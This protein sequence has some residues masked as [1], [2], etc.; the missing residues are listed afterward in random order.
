MDLMLAGRVAIVTGASR[1]IGRAIAEELAGAGV[2]VLAVARDSAALQGLAQHASGHIEP[3][4]CDVLDL[5]AVAKLPEQAVARFGR[6][7][8]VVNNA[9]G[10]SKKSFVEQSLADWD[11]HL[12]FNVL[13]PAILSRAAGE[14][15]LPQRSGK[16]INMA[17]TAAVRGVPEIVPYCT[18]K[19][20][21]VQLTKALAVEWAPLGVQV[22]AI[23]PGSTETEAM[24][25]LLESHPERMKMM[26]AVIPSGRLGRP[27]EIAKLACFLASPVSD[28][29][30]GELIMVD[31]G[32]TAAF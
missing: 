4:A 26:L 27:D 16:V 8:I 19:G 5:D 10:A 31:G 3:L 11:W 12:K 22:N 15:F 2:H 20:A 29:I 17:S 21:L 25:P 13:A 23:G 28:H 9:G 6:L 24:R 30:T 32:K 18:V 14:Y 1:G 7:D